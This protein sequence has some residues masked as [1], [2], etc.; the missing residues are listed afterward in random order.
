MGKQK[1]KEKREMKQRGRR[2][3]EQRIDAHRATKICPRCRVGI[4]LV[5][6]R[7]HFED[8]HT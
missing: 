3:I 2:A 7:L 6:A 4:L 5:A 1:E 8:I